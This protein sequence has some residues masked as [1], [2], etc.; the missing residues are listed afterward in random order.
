MEVIKRH[1][2]AV[3]YYSMP[4]IGEWAEFQVEENIEASSSALEKLHLFLE[5]N[6]Y[7]PSNT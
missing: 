2:L 1:A 5:D 7:H 3:T 4:C 6:V